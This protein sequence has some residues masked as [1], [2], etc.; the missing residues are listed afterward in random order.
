MYGMSIDLTGHR[1]CRVV[2]TGRAPKNGKH[3]RW[4]Y[5]CDC[6]RVGMTY[7]HCLQTG[8]TK[9]CGCLRRERASEPKPQRRT[10][11]RADTPL[12]L[13]WRAMLNRCENPRSKS[14][15]NYGARGVR[16]CERWHDF[17]SFLADMGE[18]PDGRTLERTDNAGNYEPGNV[19]WATRREQ[20]ANTRRSVPPAVVAT[21]VAARRTG[22]SA[23][24]VGARLGLPQS[25]V[26]RIA[27]RAG[28][29]VDSRR[30]SRR[31]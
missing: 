4:A 19:R 6:G 12:Y 20:A 11:G 27:K 3:L 26:N 31:V 1:F 13:V 21:I 14:F 23:P 22:E 18:R 29:H 5:Q 2:V 8:Q 10:H 24:S 7:A 30:R 15:H 28:V 25:T 9:S 17:A 16:V